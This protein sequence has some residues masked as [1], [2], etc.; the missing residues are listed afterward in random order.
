MLSDIFA[1]LYLSNLK[2]IR[3]CARLVLELLNTILCHLSKHIFL[4]YPCPAEYRVRVI[5]Y[6]LE[7]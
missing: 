2:D 1:K 6:T 4:S 7:M 3:L 5:K